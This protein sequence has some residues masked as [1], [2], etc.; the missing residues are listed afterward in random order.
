[1]HLYQ[2]QTRDRLAWLVDDHKPEITVAHPPDDGTE[3]IGWICIERGIVAPRKVRE[4]GR[5][6]KR[7]MPIGP[8]VHYLFVREAYRRLGAARYLMRISGVDLASEWEFS[9][10]TAAS[11][12]ITKV[13]APFS[14]FNP[15]HARFPKRA[16][17]TEADT[18]AA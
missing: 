4:R 3:I 16:Q 5:Y 10:K 2:R 18:D 17:P 9:H 13:L 1:M 7:V 6:V 8:V 12:R 14:R 11:E 15:N